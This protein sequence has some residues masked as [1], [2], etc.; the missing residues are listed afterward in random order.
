MTQ[1]PASPAA[2]ALPAPTGSPVTTQDP[3]DHG[4]EAHHRL[5]HDILRY[6]P[7]VILPRLAGIVTVPIVTRL[8]AP[9][10]M[11]TY[12]LVLANVTALGSAFLSGF[13]AALL[14]YMPEHERDSEARGRLA[15]TLLALASAIVLAVV[16]VGAVVL[17]VTGRTAKRFGQL[18][19]WGLVLFAFTGALQ[20]LS[21]VLRGQR[22][23]GRYTS[24][25]LVTGYGGLAAGLLLVL[26]LHFGIEGLLIGAVV[27]SLAGI[28]MAWRTAM[29]GRALQRGLFSRVLARE[30]LGFS[31]F[32]SAGNAAYWLLS[33]SDRWLLR[34]FRGA[35]AVGLYGVSYDITSKT[36]MLF[37]TA[38]G[39]AL[40][41]LSISAWE[42]GGREATEEFLASSTRTYLLIMLPATVGLGLLA[43]ALVGL[44]AAPAYQPG[45][46]VVP[47]VAAA[48]FLFGLLDIAGRGLTLNK[49]PDLEARN[50]L[51]A[52]GLSVLLNLLLIPRFGIVGAA[53][54]T[55]LGYLTLL[56]MHVATV[57][58]FVHWRFPWLTLMRSA[59][60]C[61]AMTGVVLVMRR[62]LVNT[63]RGVDV[64]AAVAA[65]AATYGAA[66]VALGEISP[67]RAWRALASALRP[68]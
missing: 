38:F 62:A 57:R 53:A 48:M 61:L 45:A 39:L 66:I 24:I 63:P 17:M 35:E 46:I 33:L 7:A 10:I 11:G 21:M 59:I 54:V 1:P 44:L 26:A 41:P 30:L 29:R 25:Q 32:I 22:N 67:A 42:D 31:F 64:V 14:R 16:L 43:R 28:V 4:R 55:S 15:T 3:A 65:G 20:L 8:F 13:G 52:G 68:S 9:E 34:V 49:R 23:V 27:A 19:L 58:R 6:L 37:V 47:F 40:Q 51:I 5:R 12:I 60:A 2:A 18:M 50:F 36:T 56:L